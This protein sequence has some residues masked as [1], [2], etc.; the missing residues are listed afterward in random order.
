MEGSSYYN[1]LYKQQKKD[2][3]EFS[4]NTEVLKKI[5]NTLTRDF[6]DEQSDVN[7]ELDDL[8][9]ELNKAVRHD[10]KFNILANE[11]YLYKE[12][13][14]TADTYLDSVVVSL[15]NEIASLNSKKA[16]AEQNMD[17]YH[18]KYEEKKEEERQQFFDSINIFG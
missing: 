11:S 14:T 5:L 8:K 4:R 9:E 2:V 3:K 16:S 13:S 7:G 17:Y 18:L 1:N 10:A 6:Y 12:K 15:E